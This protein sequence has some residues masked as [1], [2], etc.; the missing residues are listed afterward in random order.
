MNTA[1]KQV[2]ERQSAQV[3]EMSS[4]DAFI[5]QAIQS[6]APVE[7]LER[8]FSLKE[9]HDANEAKKAFVGAMQK[10][11]SIKPALG[12]S[13]KVKFNTT[14]GTTEYNFC[15]LPDIEKA[16]REPLSECGLMY[17]FENLH[18]EKEFGIRCVV[19][20]VQGHSE[21]TEMY[22]PRDDSGNKN[23][24]QG[25]GSTSTYLMRYTLI[26]AFALTTADEDDD[27][28]KAGDLPYMKLLMHNQAVRENFEVV[29][30]IKEA[31]ALDD[32]TQLAEYF[33]HMPETVKHSLWVAPTKGGIFTTKEIAKMKSNEAAQ[34]RNDYFARKNEQ[35]Q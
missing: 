7:T 5:Q 10:F 13:S 1:A 4:T 14:K 8:L 6:N 29:A 3:M 11:Q 9:R 25:I 15:A 32:Y 23:Q 17:R 19:T 31:L 28:E 30:A 21:S 33:D 34:A 16:L 24:I 26:A 22:A 2:A 12:R 20:H 18:N 35:A 27:G